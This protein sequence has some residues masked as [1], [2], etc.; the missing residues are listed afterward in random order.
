MKEITWDYI[1]KACEHLANKI[2]CDGKE[3][4]AIVGIPRGGLIIAVKM[5][6]LLD[7]PLKNKAHGN[8]LLCDDICDS[9]LTLKVNSVNH[10]NVT[11][12]SVHKDINSKFIPDYYYEETNEW[13]QYPWE[14]IRTSKVDHREYKNEEE[15]ILS[16]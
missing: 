10:N 5:S 4:E 15:Y 7:I 6:H 2:R 13:I 1:D 8:I 16:M 14:T 3:F 11:T 12:L 9:G